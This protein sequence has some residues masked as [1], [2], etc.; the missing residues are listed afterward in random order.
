MCIIQKFSYQTKQNVYYY[1]YYYDQ[2][3]YGECVIKKYD[4]LKMRQ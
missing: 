3:I 2:I 4:S 1:A